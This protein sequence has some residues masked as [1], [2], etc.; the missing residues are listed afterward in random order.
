MLPLFD[1]MMQ[2]QNGS[3]LDALS[4]QFGIAREQAAKAMAALTPAFSAGLKRTATTPVDFSTMM[5]NLSSGNYT[6]YFED[7]SS[8]F[9]PQGIADG[10]SVLGQ[11]F[12]SKETSRA[13]AAQAAQMTG[14]GQDVLK[15]MMPALAG[16]LMGGLLKQ[17]SDQ[18]EA[19]S[20][21]YANQQA[22]QEMMAPWMQAM[23]FQKKGKPDPTAA[24]F[25]NPFAQSMQAMFGGKAASAPV[26]GNPFVD[27]PFTKAFQEM[28]ATAGKPA[29]S[30]S[31][32][33]QTTVS[34]EA[35]FGD[36]FNTMFDS[37]L[38]VQK[39]YQKSLESIFD[40]YKQK[41]D[42]PEPA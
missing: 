25:D 14:I 24:L 27:N 28:M 5:K 32:N 4:K 37:G 26:T 31:D 13:I 38:E 29:P 40:A 23:G 33:G 22:M 21:G 1:M 39:N 35:A 2:A 15:A 11:I 16:T 19:T 6:Q 30:P 3:S 8:A 12:G 41:P 34:A 9:S 10:N 17:A 36:F 20:Q 7:L 42:T 18:M